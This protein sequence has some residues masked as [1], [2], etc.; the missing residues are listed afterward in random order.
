MTNLPL[1]ET[2]FSSV[3]PI[4]PIL[5]KRRNSTFPSQ[6]VAVITY[7]RGWRERGKFLFCYLWYSI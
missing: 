4:H 7:S 1:E 2:K 6:S 3:F 5:Q